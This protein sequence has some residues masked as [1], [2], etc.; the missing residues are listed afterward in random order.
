MIAAI[1]ADKDV[2]SMAALFSD[3]FS[4][5]TITRPG[6]RKQS[7]IDHAAKAFFR[8]YSSRTDIT[9]NVETDFDAAISLALASAREAGVPLLV[10]GSFYLVAEAKRILEARSLDRES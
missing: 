10:T 3:G 8:N 6:N 7:D 1:A 4:D 9:L 5:I 2:D